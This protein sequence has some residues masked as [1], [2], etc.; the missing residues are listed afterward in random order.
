MECVNKVGSGGFLG[1]FEKYAFT[2][3]NKQPVTIKAN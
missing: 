2:I 3:S 1:R